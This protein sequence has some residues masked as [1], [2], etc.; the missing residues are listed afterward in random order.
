MTQIN[1][2][3]KIVIDTNVLLVS[4]SKKS[5]YYWLY[6]KLLNKEFI[7]CISNDII[8][9]YIEILSEKYNHQVAENIIEI[10]LIAKNVQKI[11]PYFNW[12]LIIA[13][14]HDNKFVDCA[15][16]SNADYPVTNDKHFK[17]PE[18]C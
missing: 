12:N 16:A 14:P 8:N 7:L 6:K 5:Q 1:K 13:D 15:I 4:I 2:M 3:L 18:G 10:L 9:E 17:S 11:T